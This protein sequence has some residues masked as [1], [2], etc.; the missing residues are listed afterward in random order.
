MKEKFIP[1]NRARANEKAP[2]DYEGKNGTVLGRVS[3]KS[4]Y[5]V[6]FDD[7]ARGPAYLDSWMLD[8]IP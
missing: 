3:G 8:P 5:Q 2:G 1:G 7:D 4:E 6:Q